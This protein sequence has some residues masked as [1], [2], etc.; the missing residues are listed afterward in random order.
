MPNSTLTDMQLLAFG[1]ALLVELKKHDK[2][3]DL[4]KIKI[5]IQGGEVQLS[6]N[7][8][9]I[10]L[11]SN[12]G[13]PSAVASPPLPALMSIS[14]DENE[15]EAPLLATKINIGISMWK[16]TALKKEQKLRDFLNGLNKPEVP[17]SPN[18][19]V[20]NHYEIKFDLPKDSLSALTPKEI[21]K[22]FKRIPEL[23]TAY[24]TLLALRKLVKQPDD[25]S[26]VIE[27]KGLQTALAQRSE[28]SEWLLISTCL[29]KE[30]N[31]KGKQEY[32]LYVESFDNNPETKDK[33]KQELTALSIK[34]Q[35]DIQYKAK[36]EKDYYIFKMAA[37]SEIIEAAKVPSEIRQAWG[38]FSS[39]KAPLNP[40]ESKL[41]LKLEKTC[42]AANLLRRF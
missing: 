15:E 27:R 6:S 11:S 13:E 24:H 28:E 21:E 34:H 2:K 10:T 30:W 32:F 26:T 25:N 33:L 41:L 18:E 38:F 35:L 40:A 29:K 8:Y 20:S 42:S 4:T 14:D 9:L 16:E 17:C 23:V 22:K 7:E 3:L 12:A 36:D 39:L 19:S 37:C 1:R 5:S 31:K